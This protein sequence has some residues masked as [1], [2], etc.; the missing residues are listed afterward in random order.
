MSYCQK[1]IFICNLSLINVMSNIVVYVRKCVWITFGFK[2]V[3]NA[4]RGGGGKV[5]NMFHAILHILNYATL[6]LNLRGRKGQQTLHNLYLSAHYWMISSRKMRCG[7]LA[8]KIVSNLKEED[9]L[10][11]L[12]MDGK[13]LI[14][15]NQ[16]V[17]VCI[18][19][20]WL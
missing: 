8:E 11:D 9:H 12:G 5:Q 1:Y 10:G 7:E 20:V 6:S 13:V 14:L 18:G 2:D 4:R 3:R 15:V 17:R 16:K 19:F